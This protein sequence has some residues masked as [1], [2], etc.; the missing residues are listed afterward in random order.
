MKNAPVTFAICGLGVR[1]NEAYASFQKSHPEKMKIV[2]AADPVAERRQAFAKSYGLSDGACFETAEALL[3]RPRLADVAVIATQDRQHVAQAIAALEKGY[4]LLLEKPISPFLRE[5]IALQKKA[6]ETKRLVVVCHVLRY[7]P[8]YLTLWELLRG[9]AIGRLQ[10]IDAHENVAYWHYAHSFVR[11]NWRRADESSPIILAKSCH[12][13]DIIRWIVDKP[14]R[15]VAS[16]GSLNWFQA[17]N[18]P[19]GSAPR[20]LD[21]CCAKAG[22]PY[23]AEKIY[24]SNPLSG[25]RSGNDQWP[26]SVLAPHPTEEKL[27]QALR[28]GPYGRCVYHCDNDVADHQVLA[29]EFDNGIAATFTMSAFTE[30]C[31]RSVKVTGAM[32]EIEGDT[33]KNILWLRKFGQPEQRVDLGAAPDRFAGHGGGDA[34]MMDS[35]CDLVMNGGMESRTSIDVSVESHVMALA[36]EKARVTGKAVTLDEFIREEQR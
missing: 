24:I 13:M 25:I 35:L 12:D 32:G 19:G 34:L 4:H 33:D 27:Y 15:S 3:Q 10:T 7:T 6:H 8:F 23:D 14:C 9:G 22:C 18:A 17:K 1:G 30:K 26:A 16:Y 5:C 31:Y 29:M 11:G 20:C 21:G 2:A 36:A 28:Q